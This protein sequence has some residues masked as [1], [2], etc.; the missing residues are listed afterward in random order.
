MTSLPHNLGSLSRQ[1]KKLNFSYLTSLIQFG[2]RYIHVKNNEILHLESLKGDFVRCMEVTVLYRSP[3]K[4][5]YCNIFA[6]LS[7]DR[8][9]VS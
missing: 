6:K 4:K 2:D 5:M 9:N 3:L 1:S 7:G 8:N